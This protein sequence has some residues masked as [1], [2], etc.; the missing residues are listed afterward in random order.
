[1]EFLYSSEL[2]FE[3]EKFRDIGYLTIIKWYTFLRG[4]CNKFLKNDP[5]LLGNAEGCVVE[6]DESVG[7]GGD[8][9]VGSEN[10]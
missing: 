2:I 7:G 1:M 10:M 5:I 9:I 6:I 8:R 4:L 3:V